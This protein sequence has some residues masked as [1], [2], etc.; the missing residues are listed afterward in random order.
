MEDRTAMA[1]V[2][3]LGAGIAGLSLGWALKK[4]GIDFAI[5]E[6][7][8]Y[9]GGLAR[10]FEWHGFYCDFA[11]HRLFTNDESI[12]QQLLNLVPMGR[13]L[14]R[15]RIYLNERWMRD[16]LD[17][18]EL[19][20]HLP[21]LHRFKVIWDYLFRPRSLPDDSFEN[22][23]LRRYGRSLYRLFFQ[24]YTEKL[25]GVPGNEISVSWARQ[26]VRLANPIDHYRENT[27][28][29]FQY[30]YY[31]IRGGYGAIANRLYEEVKDHVLCRP[32]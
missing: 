26:K 29:K 31:P 21:I 11:A 7:Q 2:V 15:S 5:L 4:Y 6:K 30:F 3:I 18:I 16:P 24:A 13:H 8:A 14:R 1:K 19:G 20:T 12:L 23:V 28:T 25:F 17:V 9:I 22:Y 27:K 10:S 32:R